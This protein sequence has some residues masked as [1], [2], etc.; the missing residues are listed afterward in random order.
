M[1]FEKAEEQNSMTLRGF[2]QRHLWFLCIGVALFVRVLTA[3]F[4]YGPQA[5]D[6]YKHG[7]I[8]TVEWVLSTPEQKVQLPNYRSPF[9]T[10]Y[11]SPWSQFAHLLGLNSPQRQAQAIELGLAIMSLIGFFGLALYFRHARESRAFEHWSL[12]LYAL[13]PVLPFATTRA[14]GESAAIP[15]VLIAFGSWTA[16]ALTGYQRSRYFSLSMLCFIV[17]CFFRFQAGIWLLP[18]MVNLIWRRDMKSFK[19]LSLM[20]VLALGI[21]SVLDFSVDRAPLGTILNYLLENAGGA[22]KY[23]VTPWYSTWATVAGFML[24]PFT[25]PLFANMK[26]NVYKKDRHLWILIL[27][28]VLIHS[29]IPHKEERFLYPVLPLLLIA[30]ARL[31]SESELRKFDP[32]FDGIYFRFL[33]KP[34]VIL[35][36]SVGT[37]AIAFSN[38]QSGIIE[39]LVAESEV[40]VPTLFID[41]G[42][43]IEES[44]IKE[45]FLQ[46]G[47]QFVFF[48]KASEMQQLEQLEKMKHKGGLNYRRW[49]IVSNQRGLLE[50]PPAIF[51]Q[52]LG[53]YCDE[54]KT[55]QSVLDQVIFTLNPGSNQRRAKT[56][57]LSCEVPNH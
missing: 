7:V 37:L 17:A 28:F 16:F 50:S 29:L 45:F 32:G 14:F 2:S 6:D 41:M 31:L 24:V 43:A 25:L 36:C 13:Y 55:A 21:Q 11:L 20:A 46:P 23:G 48:S 57:Y 53:M 1:Q 18:V 40:D 27:F 56:F 38:P 22:Q 10:Y 5:I 34:F 12:W 47:D 8:P 19:T 4:A 39:P 35:L 52:R 33:L 15:F 49:T 26:T 9:L 51:A 3:I 44:W 30:L 42:T 54:V